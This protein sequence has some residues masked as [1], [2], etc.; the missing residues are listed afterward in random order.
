MHRVLLGGVVAGLVLITCATP[1]HAN[2]APDARTAGVLA[3]IGALEG[4]R[5]YDDYFRGVSE[6]PPRPLTTMTVNEVQA[7]QARIDA[8][9]RSEAA[10][11]YQ[12]IRETLAML[13]ARMGLSGDE[14]FDAA[15]QDRMAIEL[16]ARAGWHPDRR[17]H[18]ALADALAKVWAALPLVQGAERGR[19]AYHGI[20]GNRALTTPELWLDVIRRGQQA[21]VVEAALRASNGAVTESVDRA[22]GAGVARREEA[23]RV[24]RRM[25]PP[26]AFGAQEIEGGRLAPSNVLVFASDPFA[27]E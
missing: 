13:K 2:P 10:G 25:A 6:P 4:P 12:I 27:M 11:R 20:A 1:G 15:L 9:S 19:S 26:T 5:G 21:G 3:F 22:A 23:P 17:D 14:L 7:W 24:L 16:M 18:E 8:K